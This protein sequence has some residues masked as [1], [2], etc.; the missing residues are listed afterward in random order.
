[1]IERPELWTVAVNGNIVSPEKGKCWV[2]KD[3]PV[4]E[5]GDYLQPGENQITLTAEKM[6]V[7]A[8]IMP[9]YIL[10]DFSLIPL[11]SGF[12]IDNPKT[13]GTGSWINAGMPFYS[14]QVSYSQ[15]FN[16]ENN[17]SGFSVSLKKWAGTICDVFVNGEKAG[18]IAFP[19]YKLDI[20]R[21][22]KPG[23]NN[24]EIAVTGSLKN[25]FGYFYRPNDKWIHGPKDWNYAPDHQPGIDG[26]YLMD[27]GLYEPFVLNKEE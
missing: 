24:V 19:P 7:F 10:G 11:K 26:M 25:T 18:V 15:K 5:I 1:M 14:Q 16:I 3:F 6:S 13:I 20:S 4:F 22:I 8:E 9:V 27:Y 21:F 2:D 23:E 12:E 17:K